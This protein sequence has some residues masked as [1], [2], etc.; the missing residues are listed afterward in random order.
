MGNHSPPLH[1]QEKHKNIN[2]VLN[3]YHSDL[4]FGVFFQEGS[5]IDL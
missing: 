1:T 5:K 4:I 3:L 2:L